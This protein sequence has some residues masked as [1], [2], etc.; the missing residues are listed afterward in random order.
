MRH[1]IIPCLRYEDA[2]RAIEFLCTAFGFVRQA[3]FADPDDPTII[4]HAQLVWQDRMVMVSSALFTPHAVAAGSKTPTQAGGVTMDL[5]LVVADV[6]AHADQ[7]RAAGATIIAEPED[8]PHGGR[9]YAVRD[10]EGHVWSF[11]SY[12]P[13]A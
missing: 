5:Y 12:D 7:A 13:W 8:K 3:V 4:H 2:P 9:G 11:G 1:E 10:P 6:D